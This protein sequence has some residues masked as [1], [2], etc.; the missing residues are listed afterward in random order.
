MDLLNKRFSLQPK[1]ITAAQPAATASATT[2]TASTSGA[3][4]AT[5]PPQPTAGFQSD[6]DTDPVF[7]QH[8]QPPGTTRPMPDSEGEGDEE[9]VMEGNQSHRIGVIA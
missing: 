2:A 9:M 3:A 7:F 1:G 4:P 8:I 5:A 6:T